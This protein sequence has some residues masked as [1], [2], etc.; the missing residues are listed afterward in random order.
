MKL[1]KQSLFISILTL[2]LVSPSFSQVYMLGG[3]PA[4]VKNSKQVVAPSNQE[5]EA[6]API[7]APQ[8]RVNSFLDAG[9]AFQGLRNPCAAE[10]ISDN[11]NA[12]QI[13][14]CIEQ[15]SST[16][17][18]DV[19]EIVRS[20]HVA[21]IR[22]GVDL[23]LPV[24]KLNC[25]VKL[26]TAEGNLIIGTSDKKTVCGELMMAKSLNSLAQFT[27]TNVQEFEEGA[28]N[29]L[30]LSGEITAMEIN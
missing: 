1:A 12:L 10:I 26:Y 24:E 25:M 4:K 3:S 20:I 21:A 27:F 8:A 15:Y 17:F 14:A 19:Q 18:N 22:V 2:V 13:S 11:E 7:I 30:I 5:R 9:A 29:N 28:E 23:Q 6:A 16:G